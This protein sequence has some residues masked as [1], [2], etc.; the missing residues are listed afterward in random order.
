MT[1]LAWGVRDSLTLIGRSLRHIPRQLDSL[2]LAV[3]LPVVLLLLFVYVF[4][5]AMNVGTQYVDYVVPGIILLCAGF[6]AGMT[7][8]SVATDMTT[9]VIDRFRTLP[10]LSSAVLTGHVVSSLVRNAI[11]TALVLGV[12]FLAGFR[13]TATPV[14]W[15]AAIGVLA[16][17][18]VAISWFAVCLGLLARTPEAAS[19][20]TF[21][22]AFL[23]YVSSAFVPPE[24]MPTVLRGF[25]EY[26]PITPV[27]ETT[28]GL[29]TGTGIGASLW[30]S[31][32]WFGGLTLVCALWAA[33]LFRRRTA[34]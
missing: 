15:V 27:I 17:F 19:G 25:A 5:G 3:I 23:P 20:Y 34:Q 6:G 31:L 12:A 21:G 33:W 2:L 1:S 16:L 24:T 7:A 30:L 9:G 29:L 14:E 28:R 32:A 4:G 26:Q 8:V 18:V 11:S 22:F 10:I 13:S